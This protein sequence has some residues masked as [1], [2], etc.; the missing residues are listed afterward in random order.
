MIQSNRDGPDFSRILTDYQK[1][2]PGPQSELRRCQTPE[3]L[4]LKPA[5]YRLSQ[6]RTEP[7]MQRVIFIVPF[8]KVTKEQRRA[9]EAFARVDDGKTKDDKK[10]KLTPIG[11]RLTRIQ[12]LDT[13]KDII[14]LRRL[15]KHLEPAFN[16]EKLA[17]TL[18]F[19]DGRYPGKKRLLTDYFRFKYA[20]PKKGKS[21]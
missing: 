16:W 17:K 12:R 19:W 9:G 7:A 5:F 1:M 21:K 15:I 8:V 18:Y 13:P 3:E 14:E 2:T 11:V 4:L 20:P 10:D 6:G